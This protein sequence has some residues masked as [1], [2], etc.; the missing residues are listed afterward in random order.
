M[1]SQEPPLV[2]LLSRS[3]LQPVQVKNSVPTVVPLSIL[4]NTVARFALT[5]AAW[6]YDKPSQCPDTLSPDA[7]SRSLQTTLNSY[8]QWA[9]QLGWL[10]YNPSSGQRHG[11][12]SISYGSP[13][14][15]GIELI[16]ARSS[17]PLAS[18]LPD[19]TDRA[20]GGVW[21][22]DNF[23]SAG[24][25]VPTD[26]ALL[27][28]TDH[29]GLV[30]VSV[31]LTNFA[32]GA[33]SI[34]FRIAHPVAD[35]TTLFQFV[36]DWAAVH[37]AQIQNLPSP[38]LT[39]VFNPSLLDK[40]ASGDINSP[41]P[42]PEILRIS[43]SLPMVKYDW[44]SSAS[45]CP[46][47]ML[48]GTAVP[49]ELQGTDL[50]ERADPMPWAEWDVFAPVSHHLVYFSPSEVQRIWEAASAPGVR[51]SRLDALLAFIWRLVVRARDLADDP[52]P[53]H[54]IVTIGARSRVIPPLPDTFLGSPIVL[55]RVSLSGAQISSTPSAAAAAIRA[56]VAQ[57]TPE[58]IG[59]FLHDVA[60]QVN[61]QRFWRAF[62]GARHSI[63]T[64]WQSLDAYGVDFGAG[65]PPRYV[66]A[67]MPS[68]DGCFHVMEAGPPAAGRRNGGRWYDEPVCLSLHLRADVMARLLQDPE[69]RKHR[70]GS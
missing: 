69:L 28:P 18:L 9:G 10:P 30:S 49:P 47:P 8:P 45:G 5:S 4:D 1:A 65:R 66:D 41:S 64:S 23:P 67:V 54:M 33:I 53:V 61:P 44:W 36:K 29:S 59:A 22:A 25:L 13:N 42:D 21:N 35:A 34:A 68:A 56:S 16:V 37:R 51:V 58:A 14:D 48:P 32:C 40:A 60:H 38:R 15:P 55:A 11:R 12:V 27:S 39:P 26:I 63:V 6:Y 20:E 31:Q 2:E 50:G 52:D 62:L 24:L 57:L 43:R 3:R 17:Q 70:D 7:L 46:A 19:S